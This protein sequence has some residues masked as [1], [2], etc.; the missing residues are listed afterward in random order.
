MKWGIQG[1]NG[2]EYGFRPETQETWHENTVWHVVCGALGGAGGGDVVCGG[3]RRPRGGHFAGVQ[4]EPQRD[5]GPVAGNRRGRVHRAVGPAADEGQRRDERGVRLERSV[6]HRQQRPARDLE[7]AVRGGGRPAQSHRDVPPVRHARVLR[8]RDEP[9]QL[10]HPGL[11]REH[12]HGRLSRHVPGGFPPAHHQRRLLPQVGQRPQ[13]GRRMAGDVP[14]PLGPAGHRARDAEPELRRERGGLARQAVVRAASEQSGILRPQA[15]RGLGGVRSGQRPDEG[16]SR[17]EPRLLQGGRGRLPLPGGALAGGPDEGGRAAPGRGEARA[18]LFL[19][20]AGRRCVERR[21]RGAGAVA[22]QH[23]ARFPRL[24]EPPGH[25]VRQ[26]RGTQRRDAL[27]R[28]PGRAAAAGTLRRRRDAA[29]GRPAA[30]RAEL[31]LR[32][33]PA[34]RLRQRRGRLGPRQRLRRDARAVARQRLR[35][36]Q[37]A[38]PRVLLHAPGPRPGLFGR[39]QP[40]GHA[41]GLRRRVP[42]LGADGLP[43]PVGPAADPD[44]APRAREFR[45]LRPD[46]QVEPG[47]FHRV[48]ARRR[49]ELRDDALPAEQPL[50]WV[51]LCAHERRFPVGRLPL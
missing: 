47:Q 49:R 26:R 14:G 38:P 11:Q 33:E 48:A 1:Y 2:P 46:R 18:V 20:R 35:G 23:V 51:G 19:R 24:G 7:H 25:G 50:G 9:P 39:Q 37:A 22:V 16:G 17:G 28:A 44:A 27:R 29:G 30:Q 32:R 42:A 15:E 13:L 10:R 8:Q 5:C 6:R 4:P 45:P 12:A 21:L 31:A 43:G 36:P 40:R 41:D 34:G 3:G